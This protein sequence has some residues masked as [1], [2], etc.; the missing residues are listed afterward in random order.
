MPLDKANG[1]TLDEFAGSMHVVIPH[2]HL[3]EMT[4]LLVPYMKPGKFRAKEAVRPLFED[5]MDNAARRFREKG[6]L[7]P[8]I[9]DESS[10]LV[11]IYPK[12]S[13]VAVIVARL[14]AGAEHFVTREY[15]LPRAVI[16][17]LLAKSGKRVPREH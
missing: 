10:I 12:E 8:I 11:Q 15:D 7:Y 1:E 3:A 4:N 16:D 13:K 17:G 14:I 5:A 6:A 2:S 9:H